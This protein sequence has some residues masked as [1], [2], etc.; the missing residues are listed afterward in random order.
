MLR[1]SSNIR[2]KPKRH[3]RTQSNPLRRKAYQM[4]SIHVTVE[5]K[6]TIIGNFGFLFEENLHE[7]IIMIIVAPPFLNCF[8]YTAKRKTGVCWQIPRFEERFR[9]APFS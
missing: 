1:Q 7:E 3:V 4:F 2:K 9:K 5:K 6:K 8:P